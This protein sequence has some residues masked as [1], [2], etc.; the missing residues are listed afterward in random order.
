MC[1]T[2]LGRIHTRVATLAFLPALLGLILWAATGRSAWLELLGIYLLLGV[3]LDV[4]V[5]PWAIKYQPPWMTFVLAL[6]E[7][8]LLYALAHLLDIHLSPLEAIGYYWAAWLLAVGTKI[9]LLPIA[10]LTYLE[11]AGEFRRDEWS[12]PPSLEL[13]P[14]MPSAPRNGHGRVV[15]AAARPAEPAA[16]ETPNGRLIL[17]H[18]GT[19]PPLEYPVRPDVTIGRKRCD[20]TIADPALE[21]RHAVI[22]HFSSGF[23]IRSLH[24]DAA[25]LVNDEPVAAE[26]VLAPGDRI[27][28]GATHLRV[29]VARSAPALP[30]PRAPRGELRAPEPVPK[31]IRKR[32]KTAGAPAGEFVP[33]KGG[34]HRRRR[35]QAT[36]GYATAL[37]FLIVLADAIGIAFALSGNG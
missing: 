22:E 35:S 8:G 19:D 28:V 16:P 15:E 6:A 20:I 4:V 17:V 25:V 36:S 26:W 2:T 37:A 1:P 32:V 7:L 21:R 3:A 27:C 29:E 23:G 12:I 14:I 9:V 30:T 5:Y 13:I 31:A 10:S 24:A 33:P 18:E 11:S 34:L